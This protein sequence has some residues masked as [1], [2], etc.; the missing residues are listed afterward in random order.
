MEGQLIRQSLAEPMPCLSEE[1]I[2]VNGEDL[3]ERDAG[4]ERGDPGHVLKTPARITWDTV[5]RIIYQGAKEFR[6]H[7]VTGA[8]STYESRISEV[9]LQ[10]ITIVTV[11]AY[12]LLFFIESSR[13][14]DD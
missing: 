1:S 3:A 6:G 7:E 5:S 13:C 4:I 11:I 2:I 10:L 8:E 12:S 14:V 9:I